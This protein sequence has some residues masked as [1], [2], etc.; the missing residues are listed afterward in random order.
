M[1]SADVD[2][3]DR[4]RWTVPVRMFHLWAIAATVGVCVVIVAGGVVRLTGSG[5]GCDDWPNCN[6]ER[7]V[8][9]SS[10]HAAI[11]QINRLLSAL[12]GI[13]ALVLAVACARVRPRCDGLV[14]PSIGLLVAILANGVLG[15]MTVRGD[16]HPALVQSHFVLALVAVTFGMIAADRSRPQFDLVSDRGSDPVSDPQSDPVS[17]ATVD[18]GRRLPAFVRPWTYALAFGTAIAI[19]TGTVV[20]G[21]G[22]HAGDE[23]AR[24]WGFDISTVA[25]IHAIVVLVT[26]VGFL[27]LLWRLRGCRLPPRVWAALSTW[28][29]VAVVQGAIGYLQYFNGVPEVLVGAH[30]AGATLLWVATVHLVQV[31]VPHT[32]STPE[33]SRVVVSDEVLT[34]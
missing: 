15:G 25:R 17:D 16:L 19:V 23:D 26:V 34:R 31:A 32:A 24:R 4:E 33:S 28:L 12:V 18:A 14:W 9:V 29:F 6:T 5:L 10:L 20:T 8:D 30:I 21:T 2:G 22:P 1:E 11:E 13:P 7:F 3:R 27:A